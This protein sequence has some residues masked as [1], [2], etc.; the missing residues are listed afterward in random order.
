MRLSS[1]ILLHLIFVINL[2]KW[3][4]IYDGLDY[5]YVGNML[6]GAKFKQLSC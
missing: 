3:E 1:S 2:H 6:T 5:G 4:F